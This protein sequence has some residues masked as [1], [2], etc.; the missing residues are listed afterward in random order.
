MALKNLGIKLKINKLLS[1][2]CNKPTGKLIYS[3]WTVD[4]NYFIFIEVF[5]YNTNRN[6]MGVRKIRIFSYFCV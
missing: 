1:S 6:V 2:K 3:C 5:Y 4:F